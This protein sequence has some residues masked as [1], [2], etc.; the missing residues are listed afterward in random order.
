M[1]KY[2]LTG[3]LSVVLMLGACGETPG[4]SEEAEAEESAEQPENEAAEDN[5]E[6]LQELRAENDSLQN[7]IAELEEENEDVESLQDRITELETENEALEEMAESDAEAEIDAAEEDEPAS[8]SE[9]KADGYEEESSS[10]GEG[11]RSDPR[12]IGSTAQLDVT[13]NGDNYDDRYEAVVNLTV[14]DIIIGDEAYDMLLA[15]NQF[16]D[17]APEG[18][19]WALINASIEL[20]ESETDD[21]A[22]YVMD[23]FKIVEGDGSSAPRESAVT[24]DEYGSED[25]YSGGTSSGYSSVLIPEDNDFLIKYEGFSSNTVFYKIN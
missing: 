12:T 6:A 10:D 11:T 13:I 15:E 1:K 8:D 20:V 25:I 2:L 22:Y 4:A 9:D 19:Q 18:Y 7:R 17:P 5:S 21:Y 3:G 16:N 14:N 23:H 24:P